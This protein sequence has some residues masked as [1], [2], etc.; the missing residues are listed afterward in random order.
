MPTR[1]YQG[2]VTSIKFKD[3]NIG[4]EKEAYAGL[5]RTFEMFQDAVNY[6]L[7]ALAA[8]AAHNDNPILASFSEQVKKIWDSN[9]RESI[10]RC[11]GI[12][13]SYTFEE[14]AD[15]MFHDC[16]CK[17]ALPY[18]TQYLLTIGKGDGA[19]TMA[20]KTITPWLC[21]NDTKPTFP[22]SKD[23]LIAC[24][25]RREL[26]SLLSKPSHH[27]S[28]YENFVQD[29]QLTWAG[30][31]C[32]KNAFWT[33]LEL[34]QELNFAISQVEKFP[35]PEGVEK[36][37]FE[38]AVNYWKDHVHIIRKCDVMKNG[39]GNMNMAKKY[40][41]LV[42]MLFPGKVSAAV[43]SSILL[44]EKLPEL[45]ISNY[46]LSDDP[47][48]LARGERG[49]VYKGVTA[50]PNWEYVS[51]N[52]EILAFAEALKTFHGFMLKSEERKV[53]SQNIANEIAYIETGKGKK[54]AALDYEETLIPVLGGDPRFEAMKKLVK[55]ISPDEVTE[56]HISSRTLQGFE[57]LCKEWLELETSG[58]GEFG[59]LVKKVREHQSSGVRFGSE[60]LYEALC[61]DEYRLIWHEWTDKK[62]PRS[63][64]VLRDFAE[65]QRLHTKKAQYE[66]PV[67][68]S[69][70]NPVTSPRQ[71]RFF[72]IS[73]KECKFVSGKQE[74]VQVCVAVRNARSRWE[75][76]SAIIEF[77][78]PRLE[79]D[80]MGRNASSWVKPKN[81]DAPVSW[82][83]PIMRAM[84]LP[85]HLV[86]LEH[87]PDVALYVKYGKKEEAE[88]PIAY[89]NLSVSLKV[90]LL[91]KEVGKAELWKGQFWGRNNEKLHLHWPSTYKAT[92][93]VEPWWQNESITNYGFSVLGVDL[94]MRSAFAWSLIHVSKCE[95]DIPSGRLIGS[96]DNAK[97][98]GSVRKQGITRIDGE[99]TRKVKN[100][101][102]PAVALP[103]KEDLELVKKIYARVG[104]EIPQVE[105]KNL[106][107]LG[108]SAL[109]EF[110]LLLH[111]TRICQSCLAKLSRGEDTEASLEGIQKNFSQGTLGKD[112]TH[113]CNINDIVK[114]K[115]LLFEEIAELRGI[116]PLV[117]VDVTNLLLPRKHGHWE[118]V[119]KSIPG[120]QGAG[121]MLLIED[122]EAHK[123]Q[124]F[125]RGGIS[126]ERIAQL[127]TLRQRLQAMSK[128]LSCP[129][130][131]T[132]PFGR[133]MKDTKVIEPCPQILEKLEN[134]K[135]QRVNVIAH[136]IV[137]QALG[138]RLRE[139]DGMKNTTNRD[140][141]HGE[142][143]RIPNRC[144]VDFVVMENLKG[145]RTNIDRTTEENTALMRWSHRQIAAKVEQLLNEVFGIPVLFTHAAYTSKFDCLYSS[146]GFRP[147]LMSEKTL[148]Y[149][150]QARDG[151]L[152][153]LSKVY[154]NLY[155]RLQKS[156]YRGK[157]ALIKPHH[158][159]GGEMFISERN[160][161]LTLR[162]ADVNAATNIAWRGIAAPDAL[163]LLHLVRMERKKNGPVL[164]LKNEREKA[165]K[166]KWELNQ[167]ANVN[168][169]RSLIPAFFSTPEW[170]HLSFA[171]YGDEST[172]VALTHGE[173]IWG[174]LKQRHWEL[175]HRYNMMLL[176]KAGIDTSPLEKLLFKERKEKG[177]DSD[178][179][180]R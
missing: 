73:K 25:K 121:Q 96:S 130:G 131:E 3:S 59:C 65:W 24:E 33:D 141:F 106:Y 105:H 163:H 6:H 85:D 120:W 39:G 58:K 127:E 45:P 100:K 144:P 93:K 41:A 98:Y 4:S 36:Q 157:I 125:H 136:E 87:T 88:R 54:S 178:D 140:V 99:R 124:V 23:W 166:G 156:P 158:K 5:T 102:V 179:I 51:K 147:E 180:P 27:E 26:V 108:K 49:Y 168:T 90:E 154:Q 129:L 134:M 148:R 30:I 18:I 176:H 118:W 109:H 19:I 117:A 155:D 137:A 139:S 143:E 113:A 172:S 12:S 32:Q 79:R 159:N 123:R 171:K 57:Q 84:G 169:E 2:R 173:L 162:N 91:Q 82:V 22:L 60:L 80:E 9:L 66:Q 133:L 20:S 52:W 14:I 115:A 64:N 107:D 104:H 42:F 92:G 72:D 61:K 7:V 15:M 126:I 94:G 111:R 135:E 97:W 77:S 146:P 177:Q 71:L 69:A 63:S 160:G 21:F 8:M 70:A 78:A 153:E 37:E 149:M 29:M 28:V 81:E 164:C 43:L 10:S 67:R 35:I 112:I 165:L 46:P 53:E 74:K 44:N 47:F 138:V 167:Y 119:A 132:V 38:T 145:Y 50:W 31:K 161:K 16:P 86:K 17:G 152:V 40:A 76:V 1:I 175:C 13:G 48:I 151:N 55:E 11:L 110:Y 56:Y 174:V 128:V 170:Y 150:R 34:K 116:L 103:A 95:S 75:F 89:L 101:E 122:K 114:V 142:Y 62:H 68:V 83:Q